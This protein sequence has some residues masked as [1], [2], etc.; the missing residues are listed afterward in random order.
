MGQDHIKNSKICFKEICDKTSCQKEFHVKDIDFP[1][2]SCG[3]CKFFC[4]NLMP[5]C[6]YGKQ[7]CSKG[8]HHHEC[9]ELTQKILKEYQIES[10]K[11]DEPM[12]L[13]SDRTQSDSSI[14]SEQ[15]L[16][17]SLDFRMD[18]I[19]NDFYKFKNLIYQEHMT[20]T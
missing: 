20:D 10:E 12:L 14:Q 2:K 13:N 19:K 11:K 7:K 4:L 5:G 18:P 6:K 15:N 1:F 17:Q 16:S 9:R 8:G 3:C